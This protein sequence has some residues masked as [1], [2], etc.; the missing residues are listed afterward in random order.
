[1][2]LIEA[3]GG[4]VWRPGD[5]GGPLV[6]IVHRPRYDDWSLPKGKVKR[7]EHPIAAAVREV[8][9]ET[10]VRAAP[11][12]PLPRIHYWSG[13]RPK[14]VDYWA[15]ATEEVASFQPNSEVDGV[16]WLPVTEAADRLTYRHD[17]DLLH[18]W[19]TLPPVTGTVLLVRHADAGERWS[20]S[21]GERPLSSRGVADAE[22]LCALLALFSPGRLVSASVRRCRQTLA[23]L[24]T[25]LNL[26]IE[27]GTVF[28]EEAGD[29]DAAAA[30][31]RQL[32][33]AA[34][35]TVVCSQ[36]AIIPAVLARLTGDSRSDWRTAKGDGW[37]VPYAHERLLTVA[38]LDTQRVR[39]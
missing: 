25:A 27:V 11:Q 26:P 31:L 32:T 19:A 24:A 8:A 7:G 4:V 34:H 37:L 17:A 39:Q 10:G 29:P 18:D 1:M 21:D 9:E 6:A 2:E 28:D 23:P 33:E 3:A 38:P 36:R 22:A 15:M 20:A 12:L 14:H 16:A 5:G 35:T 30:Q 13:D